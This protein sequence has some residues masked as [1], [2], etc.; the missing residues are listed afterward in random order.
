MGVETLIKLVLDGKIAYC[1][2]SDEPRMAFRGIHLMIPPESEFEFTKRLI[3]YVISPMGYNAII[4]YIGGAMQYE[5]HP[6]INA[7]MERAV[8]P[9]LACV[10]IN[11]K[12]RGKGY[13][14]ILLSHI[15]NIIEENFPEIYLTTEHVGF[16]EKIGF[17]FVKLIDNNGKNNR[18]YCKISKIKQKDI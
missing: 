6:E 12:Y 13:G 10:V 2:I 8:S 5:S 3:K 1:R 14:K 4:F 15:K 16:Y 7:A 18:F 17:E 9:W 11:K